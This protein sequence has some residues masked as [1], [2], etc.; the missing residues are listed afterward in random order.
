MGDQ[1]SGKSSVLE[2]L[3]G[4]PFPR[5]T[6]LVTRCPIRMV[7]RRARKG[8]S[9]SA[10]VSTSINPL[11][12]T[13][14]DVA[15]LSL[16]IDKLVSEVCTGENGFA[17]DS[18]IIELTSPDAC[19]LTVVDL[20][21]IIR[22]VTAGQSVTAIGQ[23]NKLI[24]SFLMDERTIILAVIPAN[25]VSPT[26]TYLTT[27]SQQSLLGYSYS[28]HTRESFRCRSLRRTHNWCFD[29]NRSCWSWK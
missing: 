10:K 15:E 8:E 12:H 27:V 3:S 20:P 28:R 16:I 19:D 26:C 18:I 14:E 24:K 22:T 23:V 7:M 13:V 6:G 17:T 9:W 1:S 25:Q 2:A 21:G 5:G 11:Q 4:I 29:E